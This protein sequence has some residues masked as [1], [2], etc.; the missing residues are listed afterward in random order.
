MFYGSYC[1]LTFMLLALQI[2]SLINGSFHQHLEAN[3][4]RYI[5]KFLFYFAKSSRIKNET[6]QFQKNE[7]LEILWLD[8]ML[9][10]LVG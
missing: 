8:L 7:L 10:P 2:F 6:N 3:I 1:F 5:F 4:L 9:Y